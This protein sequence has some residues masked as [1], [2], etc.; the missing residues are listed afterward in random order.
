M[1]AGLPP[2]PAKPL[3][4]CVPFLPQDNDAAACD[5]SASAVVALLNDR[6]G[7]LLRSDAP[8]FWAHLAHDAS[9]A[10]ALDTYLQFRRRPHDARLDGDVTNAASAEEHDLARRVFLVHRR[11]GDGGEPNAPALATRSAIVRHRNLVDPPKVLDLCALYGPDNPRDLERVLARLVETRDAEPSRLEVYDS[12]RAEDSAR[13][14]TTTL[15]DAFADAGAA[16]AANLEQMADRVVTSAIDES[17]ALSRDATKDALRYFH[18][19]AASLALLARHAPALARRCK[20]DAAKDERRALSTTKGLSGLS[21]VRSEHLDTASIGKGKAPMSSLS[22]LT[23]GPSTDSDLGF[24]TCAPESLCDA[25]ERVARETCGALGGAAGLGDASAGSSSSS[26]RIEPS[27]A[28]AANAV[29]AAV[30]RGRDAL[31]ALDGDEGGGTSRDAGPDA[32]VRAYGTVAHAEQFSIDASAAPP[33]PAALARKVR[34]VRELFPEHGEGFLAAALEAFGN[35]VSETASR[36]FEGDLPPA[37]AAMDVGADWAAYWAEKNPVPGDGGKRDVDSNTNDATMGDTRRMD[38]G[39]FA[40]DSSVWR[41]GVSDESVSFARRVDVKTET[42]GDAAYHKNGDV[43]YMTRRQKSAYGF[44]NGYDASEA[45]RHILD[46]AY[47]DEYDDSFDELNELAG[48]VADAG[49][50]AERRPFGASAGGVF[51]GRVGGG[52]P[53]VTKKTFWIENGRV[54]HAARPGATAVTASSVEEASALAAREA[55]TVGAQVLG[56]GAGGNRAAFGAAGARPASSV[57]HAR[58]GGR[59]GRCGRGAPPSDLTRP[60]PRPP[61]GS[62]A[63]PNRR[64]AGAP[65]GTRAHKNE[66]KASIGNH[67]RKKAAA[68]KMSK[69][70]VPAPTGGE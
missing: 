26:S 27:I 16:I 4:P 64:G 24:V 36:L 53:G 19:V 10:N 45:K 8:T 68:K 34:E 23:L 52:A 54:Y 3:P 6:L 44:E 33:P 47:D 69:G 43:A 32:N 58:G 14:Q 35:D 39:S 1:E 48:A 65:A 63:G 28:D 42:R 25:L 51:G 13:N 12:T 57:S 2:R 17:M 15:G 9:I 50:A 21:A 41:N 60:D 62:S 31:L 11:V 7:R 22:S 49:D 66:H 55:A 70:F 29:R 37:L 20:G 59:G 40:T 18:D 61:P 67:N 30:L 38:D 5:P 56:L 46:L